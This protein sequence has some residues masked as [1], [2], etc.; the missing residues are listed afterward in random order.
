[1]KI[2]KETFGVLSDGK[3]VYLYTLKAGDLKF[4]LSSFGAAWTSLI[5]PSRKN[6]KDDV[7]LGFS[8][9]DGYLSNSPFI[10]VTVGRVANRINS[11]GFSINGR[12]YQLDKNDGINTLH[13]GWRG[14]D[15]KLW[16]SEAFEDSTGVYVRFELDSPHGDSG[17]PGNLKVVVTYG[18]TKSNEVIARYEAKANAPTPINLTNHAYFNLAGEGEPSLFTHEMVLHS[19]S[20]V[21]VDEGLI[22]TGRLI[23]VRGSPFDFRNRKPVMQDCAA[24]YD[25]CFTIDGDPGKLRP[26]AEVYESSSGRTMKVFTTQPGV[27]FYTGNNLSNVQGKAGSI[28]PRHSGFCL[29]TQ[30][31]PDSP[32]RNDFP[33]CFFGPD[34]QYSEKSVF[35]FEI[36]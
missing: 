19:S 11:A 30:H 17:F 9:L 21:E 27:Q 34:R 7:L 23:P 16:K 35:M 33:S 15:K 28:Y 1:M 12:E 24:G 36:K 20:Y 3:K 32:N 26:C 10:G 4:C 18:L 22:P 5:V 25:H 13:G 2:K 29:E 8:G 6:G 14:F 31:F